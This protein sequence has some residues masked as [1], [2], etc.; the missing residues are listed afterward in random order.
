MPLNDSLYIV[1]QTICPDPPCYHCN[2]FT[3]AAPAWQ[4]VCSILTILTRWHN[5]L[6]RRLQGSWLEDLSLELAQAPCHPPWSFIL[7]LSWALALQHSLENK[8]SKTVL[9][10]LSHFKWPIVITRTVTYR[11][12]TEREYQKRIKLR[13]MK[14]LMSLKFPFDFPLDLNLKLLLYR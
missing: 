8:P 9:P 11:T 7:V 14:L 13:K 10:L 4:L 5:T 2:V 1:T 3:D 6:T 12:F